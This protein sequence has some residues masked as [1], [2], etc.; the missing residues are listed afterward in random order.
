M[1]DG[2]EAG[3]ERHKGCPVLLT[4]DCCRPHTGLGLKIDINTAPLPSD[5]SSECPTS[6]GEAA[7]TQLSGTNQGLISATVE[8]CNVT[9][10]GL[11]AAG[12]G[13]VLK[14]ILVLY[15]MIDSVLKQ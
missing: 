3:A 11:F 9:P 12:I 14:Q 8:N 7:S 6:G 15:Y 13:S 10:R 1:R 5:R 2:T 4:V